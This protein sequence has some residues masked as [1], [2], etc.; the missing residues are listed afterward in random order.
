MEISRAE[1]MGRKLLQVTTTKT[2]QGK[3]AWHMRRGPVKW[4]NGVNQ[5]EWKDI[6]LSLSI[7]HFD[8]G[9]IGENP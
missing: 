7:E 4:I 1:G 9:T 3:R 5:D 6:G 8:L 2:L